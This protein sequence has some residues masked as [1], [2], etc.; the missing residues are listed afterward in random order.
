MHPHN[1]KYN[2]T[3]PSQN[4]LDN[5]LGRLKARMFTLKGAAF[6]GSLMCSVE[7]IWDESIPTAATDG[8]HIW[9]N[10]YFFVSLPAPERMFVLRHELWH[11]AYNHMDRRNGRDPEFSNI[12]ADYVINNDMDREKF[13]H[14]NLG[15]KIYI[16]HQYDNDSYEVIYEKICPPEM[17]GKKGKNPDPD[18]KDSKGGMSQPG[19]H[20][21]V[22]EP[23]GT[24]QQVQDHKVRV[25]GNIVKAVQQSKMAK[26]AGI[27]PGDV[28]EMVDRF[29]N[30][31]LP[32]ETLLQN[33][34]NEMCNDDYSYRRPSRRYDDPIMPTLWSDGALEELN[35]YID[36]SGSI[37]PEMLLRF[38]SEIKY[39]KDVHK[40]KVINIIQFDCAIQKIEKM[41]DD[42]D[43][44]SIK[45][46]GRGGTSLG[47]VQ[48]HIEKTK[49][50][51]AIIFSDLFCEPM[52]DDPGSPIIWCIFDNPKARTK[53]GTDIHIKEN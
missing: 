22:R 42:H 5:M 39:V 43:F 32:W 7:F 51:A 4:E 24:P 11:I 10:P 40:P 8:L 29:L 3:L 52:H 19:L 34:F 14:A 47:P 31:I 20:N 46:H 18:G 45:F 33:Y 44:T 30:P 53:F 36:T 9:W 1:A 27:V 13:S 12:A 50:S 25:I 49:P 28:E 16:D 26:E 15:F 6:L 35:W 23:Q 48:K 21:D 2:F 38:A 41:E 17:K 37:T